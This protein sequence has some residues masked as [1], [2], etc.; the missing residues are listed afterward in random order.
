MAPLSAADVENRFGSAFQGL[1]HMPGKLHLD[2]DESQTPVD[3]PPRRVPIALKGKLKAELKRLEDLGG[4]FSES[5]RPYRLG[6]ESCH[7][8]KTKRETMGVRRSTTPQQSIE[9]K[10]LPF[11]TN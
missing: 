4:S 2:I 9:T 1:G 11:T 8:R 10:P 3:M 5:Y 7:W 6:I